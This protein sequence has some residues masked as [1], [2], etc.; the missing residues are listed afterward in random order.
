MIVDPAAAARAVAALGDLLPAGRV[1]VD[2]GVTE[3]YRH[4]QAALVRGGRP[5]AVVRPESADEVA[6]AMRTAGAHGVPVVTRGAGSG[7]SG[8]AAAIEG[9]L[10]LSTEA[11]TAIAEIDTES[12][13]ATVQAGVVNGDLAAAAAERG[14][15]YPPDP[16][17][18]AY[19]TIGGNIATNAGGLCCVKYG[20]TRESVLGL[21]AVTGAGEVLRVGGATVKRVAGLDLLS[22]LVGSEGTLAVVTEAVLRLRPVPAAPLTGAAYFPSLVAAG[23]AVVGMAEERTNPSLLELIDRPTLAAVEAWRR[24]DLDLSAAALVLFQS[25]LPGAARH[26]ELARMTRA[27]ERAGATMVV[28]AEDE[29]ESAMLMEVRRLCFPALERRGATLLEDVG[30]PRARVPALLGAIQAVAADTGAQIATFGHAGDG[31]MHP[32]IVF[33]RDDPAQVARAEAAAGGIFDAALA[34]GGTITGEHGVGT[35]KLPWLEREVGP[36]ARRLSADIKRAFDPAGILNP[37][38]AI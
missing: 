22:L 27:C 13:T 26:E 16:A 37:G 10:V 23:D 7:L 14:L 28:A 32:T 36:V 6:A 25:D 15:W 9:A 11:M 2:P 3:A 31:N 8:G 33:D 38:R 20:V 29:V 18:R 17:S 35:L 34:L 30:V 1:V 5:C 21:T 19:C 4:D 24:L 12:L